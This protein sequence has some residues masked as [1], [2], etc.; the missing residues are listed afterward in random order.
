M[1]SGVKTCGFKIVAYT[2]VATP[3]LPASASVEIAQR[4]G[5]IRSGLLSDDGGWVIV[6]GTSLLVAGG[7]SGSGADV[8]DCID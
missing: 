6:A 8:T 5:E 2:Y 7:R 4:T 3:T 1:T